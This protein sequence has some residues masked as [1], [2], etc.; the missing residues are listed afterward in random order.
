MSRRGGRGTACEAGV[1]VGGDEAAAAAAVT[2]KY[3]A[4]AAARARWEV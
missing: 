1:C 3:G 4:A 2:L